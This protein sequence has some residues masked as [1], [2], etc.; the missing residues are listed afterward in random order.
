VY[1]IGVIYTLKIIEI[2]NVFL[3]EL[4][5]DCIT[6]R[7]SE[8]E[9]I[10]YIEKRFKHI[11]L[12]SYKHRKARLLNGDKSKIWLEYFTRIG[13]VQHHRIQMDNALK[14]QDDSMHRLFE[15][16]EN[17]DK[18]DDDKILKLKHYIRE[19]IKLLSELGLGTS[20]VSAIKFKLDQI[21]RNN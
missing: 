13:F 7:L 3:N 15:L 2:E 4:V 5:K 6:Y 20:I 10:Q 9:A 8:K 11:S 19:N 12:S 18:Y 16:V 1:F 21:P 14:I 17:R